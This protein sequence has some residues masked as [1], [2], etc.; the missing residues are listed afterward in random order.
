M[1]QWGSQLSDD[2]SL[3]ADY[4]PRRSSR[5]GHD[6]LHPRDIQQPLCR[7]LPAVIPSSSVSEPTHAGLRGAGRVLLSSVR[8]LAC[9]L[10]PS[11]HTSRSQ[12]LY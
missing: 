6:L 7:Q 2:A 9:I 8:K 3:P 1:D 4:L 5:L 11:G 12:A 10:L